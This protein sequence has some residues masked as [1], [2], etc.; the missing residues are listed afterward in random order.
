MQDTIKTQALLC[1]A[2]AIE[3]GHRLPETILEAQTGVNRS[4]SH[5]LGP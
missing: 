4:A 5:L 2:C 3:A 1:T